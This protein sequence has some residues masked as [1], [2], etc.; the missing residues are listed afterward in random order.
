VVTGKTVAQLKD[1]NGISAEN[2]LA[3]IRQM[4]DEGGKFYEGGVK[5]GTDLDRQWATLV[6]TLKSAALPLG[7]LLTPT[8]VTSINNMISA[9][10][11]LGKG[12]EFLKSKV[13][14]FN[15]SAA[16]KLLAEAVKFANIGTL[17]IGKLAG[18]LPQGPKGE[19]AIPE[20][21]AERRANN[22]RLTGRA[23]AAAAEAAKVEASL[24]SGAEKVRK[25]IAE[26][27]ARLDS[28]FDKLT[29]ARRAA[30]DL[31]TPEKQQQLRD[32]AGRDIN[33]AITSGE[34]SSAAVQSELGTLDFKKAEDE[35]LFKVAD[36]A[37]GV[38]SGNAQI[39]QAL[40]TSNVD[41][42]AALLD[43]AQ[44]KW[45][46]TVNVAGGKAVAAGDVLGGVQ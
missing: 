34:F 3:A 42:R 1:L 36:R 37:A 26:S 35:D 40:T 12:F 9:V 4:T 21:A 29:S 45:G 44:K 10:Q 46:V 24:A 23:E 13:D 25:A 7:Q 16:G 20:S 31:L 17:A 43:L 28:A 41:L 2:I 18:S 33:K 19:V 32:R 30:F 39:Q 38:N 27:A 8:I 11:V 14:D 5:G 22:I 6:D 15:K